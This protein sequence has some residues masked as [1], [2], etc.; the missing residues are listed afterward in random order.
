MIT[1]T[2]KRTTFVLFITGVSGSGKTTILEH[3]SGIS[4][5]QDTVYLHFDSIGI[6]SEKEMTKNYGSGKNWQ[7]EATN[8]WIT[9]IIS[10]YKE[11][12][13]VIIEGQADI[14]FIID[15]FNKHKFTN[16]KV[17]LVHC[18]RSS[19]DARLKEKRNQAHLANDDM[20]NW[21]RYLKQQALKFNIPILDT[22][23]HDINTSIKWIINYLRDTN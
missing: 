15:A 4:D 22:T 19:R 11:K 5:L 6:P 8:T 9:K 7:K 10:K 20:E 1:T 3:L 14:K 16:Y 13:L 17:V 21:A 12:S 23:Q 2:P 18:D